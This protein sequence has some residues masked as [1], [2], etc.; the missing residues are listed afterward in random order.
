MLCARSG[1]QPQI[2]C[3]GQVAVDRFKAQQ[4]ALHFLT[5]GASREL[6]RSSR[7]PCWFAVIGATAQYWPTSLSSKWWTCMLLGSLAV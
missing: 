7:M 6:S 2:I 1:R 4:A 5:M 3:Q